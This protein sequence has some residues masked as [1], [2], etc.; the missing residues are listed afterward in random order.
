MPMPRRRGR[1]RAVVTAG[2]YSAGNP[3]QGQDAPA[4]AGE[5]PAV[6]RR[7]GAGGQARAAR[8]GDG[9]EMGGK[10]ECCGGGI[11]VGLL[12]RLDCKS[13]SE[14]FSWQMAHIQ[15]MDEADI[16]AALKGGSSTAAEEL[17]RLYGN[18]L[19]RSAFLLCGNEADAQDLV[20]DT[21]IVAVRS[22][23][24]FRGQSAL[25]TW[26]H[27][28]LL[29][30]TRRFHRKRKRL[31]YMDELPRQDKSEPGTPSRLDV[32]GASSALREAME[33]LSPRHREVIVLRYFEG[34]KMLEI[35]RHM[36]VTKGTVGS[37]LH[38]ATRRLRE[39]IP[40]ELNVFRLHGT[41]D[42]R[43]QS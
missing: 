40:E 3:E 7:G 31:V 41:Y 38:Y 5:T 30:L 13:W 25:Y 20:Q 1:V 43:K 4:T 36:G 14:P 24:R 22:V 6:R 27:G 33:K 32:Q 8:D 28:I 37:R 10:G 12:M 15:M 16:V 21:L 17:V 34:M 19:L 26:L 2:G 39:L 42:W 18:R 23:R 11:C 9:T 35:A 29:N